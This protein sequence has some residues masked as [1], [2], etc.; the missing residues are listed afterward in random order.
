MLAFGKTAF[1]AGRS[2]SRVNNYGVTKG[3][4]Y[5]LLKS[6]LVTNR[7]ILSFRKTFFSTGGFKSEN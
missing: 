1:G 3:F 6:N 4:N 5:S 2:N 7:A